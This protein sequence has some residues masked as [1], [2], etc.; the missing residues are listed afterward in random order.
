MNHEAETD[1]SVLMAAAVKQVNRLER[2]VN[3]Y[4][5]FMIVLGVFCAALLAGG[6]LLWKTYD[7]TQALVNHQGQQNYTGCLAG[8]NYRTGDQHIWHYFIQL[9]T[10][11]TKETKKTEEIINQLLAYVDKT[12]ALRNCKPLLNGR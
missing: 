6:L 9:A 12:D 11:G 4:R 1:A 8:N 7:S 2:A 5:I 3:R 10:A